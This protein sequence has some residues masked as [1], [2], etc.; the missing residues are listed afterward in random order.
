ML[1]FE[2]SLVWN[3]LQEYWL[4][5]YRAELGEYTNDHKD[6]AETL[7]SRYC[8]EICN[9]IE[10]PFSEPTV[11]TSFKIFINRKLRSVLVIQTFVDGSK[12]WQSP[13]LCSL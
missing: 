11:L 3:R 5:K 9:E 6:G 13:S 12:N 2:Y 4:L 8:I 7:A 10:H 1:V